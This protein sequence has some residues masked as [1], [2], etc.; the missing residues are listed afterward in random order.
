MGGAVTL[1]ALAL[2]LAWAFGAVALQSPGPGARDLRSAVQESRILRA[3]ND[4]APPSGALLNVLRRVDPTPAITGPEAR[5]APPTGAVARDPDVDLA[6]NSVV[7]VLGTACG[8]GV[9]G[10]GWVA[11]PGLVVTNAHVVAGEDDTTV[12]PRAGSPQ[13]EATA[14]LY[15]PRNDLALLRVPGLTA[16]PLQLAPSPDAG[17]PGATLGYPVNGPFA[18]AAAR[19]GETGQVLSDD[20][21]GR[22]PVTRL[23]TPFRGEVR[24]GNSGG[25]VVDASGRVL[26]TVFA[27]Q[28]GGGPPS[29]LGV[30][31]RVVRRALAGP[32][33]T[34]DTGPCTA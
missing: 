30:P 33:R 31:D 11:A 20:S 4:V 14:V 1:A 9:E 16:P 27:S 18:I 26:A 8:L 10:S 34:T 13:L 6:G 17:T 21:Y 23:M 19:L 15:E 29:G 12:T 32:L 5:V 25:P 28:Q 2:L 24:S 22:G 7:R 3:L